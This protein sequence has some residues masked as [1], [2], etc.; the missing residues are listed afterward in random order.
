[1]DVQMMSE[2][3]YAGDVLVFCSDG[4]TNHVNDRNMAEIL[5]N[6]HSAES[7]ARRLVN[8]AN[9]LGGSDNVTVVVARVS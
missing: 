2:S 6:T 5:R 4:L 9:A 7:A 1:L 3:L 8:H